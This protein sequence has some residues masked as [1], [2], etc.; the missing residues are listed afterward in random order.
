MRVEDL[1]GCIP[2]LLRPL[3][4]WGGENFRSVEENIYMDY[5]ILA[6]GRNI[7]NFANQMKREGD[8]EYER[9]VLKIPM[10]VSCNADFHAKVTLSP[11][12]V[13]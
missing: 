13:V 1:T 8:P 2:L 11:C 3:L 4:K 9:L 7:R 12:S 10:P 5:D 6:V